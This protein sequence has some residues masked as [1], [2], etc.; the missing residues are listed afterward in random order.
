VNS[1]QTVY[2]RCPVCYNDISTYNSLGDEMK[3]EHNSGVDKVTLDTETKEV[4]FQSGHG[5]DAT[6]PLDKVLTDLEDGVIFVE[7]DNGLT[8]EFDVEPLVQDY[9]L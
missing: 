4:Q 2:I 9:V 3:I 8:A 6:L 5:L 7:D 1:G